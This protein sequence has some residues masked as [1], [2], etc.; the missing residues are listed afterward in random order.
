MSQSKPAAD[1]S[2]LNNFLN[3]KG[4]K[5]FLGHEFKYARLL[6]ITKILA[7]SDLIQ[8][9]TAQAHVEIY[10]GNIN[11][12]VK[13]LEDLLKMMGGK[14]PVAWVTLLEIY[15]Q[16][17]DLPRIISTYERLVGASSGDIEEET[18]IF[19]HVCRVY[20]LSDW[21]NVVDFEHEDVRLKVVEV[22]NN[23]ESLK[24]LGISTTIY[25]LFISKI[26][27]IFYTDFNGS[28]QPFICFGDSELVIRVNSTIDNFEDL[29][30]LN[31]KLKDEIM[32]WYEA[33]DDSTQDQID[34]ITVYFKH[35]ILTLNNEEAHI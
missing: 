34:K 13:I 3:E 24:K 11:V 32:A 18:R 6:R 21:L 1:I 8:A 4:R 17:G 7:E 25:R 26:Y 22:N 29:F 20:L 14:S 12:G 2:Y 19:L 33:S 28:V 9:K 15:V 10:F 35:K 23:L 31:G 16:N 30:E 5:L 27:N